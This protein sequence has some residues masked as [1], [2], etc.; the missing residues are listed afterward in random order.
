MLSL[1]VVGACSFLGAQLGFAALG[2]F[3]GGSEPDGT[4]NLAIR[5]LGRRGLVFLG[6]VEGVVA[7]FLVV[8]GVASPLLS[9]PLWRLIAPAAFLGSALAVGF[10]MSLSSAQ[11]KQHGFDDRCGCFPASF[12]GRINGWTRVRAI[13]HLVSGLGVLAAA[14]SGDLGQLLDS[15]R[16]EV[17]ISI[18]VGCTYAVL[19]VLL[20][21]LNPTLARD[22]VRVGTPASGNA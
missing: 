21:S 7:L 8:G 12:D 1:Y 10:L 11:G 3:A 13:L 19:W 22:S 18:L 15:R 4:D 20:P 14:A 16:I 9:L 6:C 5:L 17:V 2:H